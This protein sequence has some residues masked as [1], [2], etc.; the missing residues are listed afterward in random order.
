M[1][2]D[3][4]QDTQVQQDGGDGGTEAAE[5]F[6]KAQVDEMVKDQ[7]AAL[8]AD[9]DT[10]FGNLWEEAKAAKAAAKTLETQLAELREGQ[11]AG[12][13]GVNAEEVQKLKEQ[14]RADE[15]KR[16]RDELQEE[17]EKAALLPSVL[18]E[19]RFLKL[20]SKVK[21]LYGEHGVQSNRID[22]LWKLTKDQYDLTDDDVP[23]LKSEPTADLGRFISE[24]LR[25][26]YPEW[27]NGSGASGG[28]AS[29]STVGGGGKTVIPRGDGSA[30]IT[31]VEGIAS[32]AVEVR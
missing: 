19:N 9:T 16:A 3:D 11:Q 17:L 12:K 6:T 29:R 5:V 26:E 15:A 14:I 32:G 30:F 8:K 18:E 20:D 13:A 21:G 24:T 31:N 1:A 7:L 4:T 23:M 27:F 2:D 10:A 25:S 28:G 22:K